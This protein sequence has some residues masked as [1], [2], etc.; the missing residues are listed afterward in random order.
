MNRRSAML[1]LVERVAEALGPDAAGVVFVGG[2]VPA[3]YDL[4]L[5]LRPT[6]DVDLTVDAT[7]PR[8][9]QL[10]ERLRKRGFKECRDPGAPVCRYELGD[11]RLLVDVMPIDPAVLG[12]S[13]RWYVPAV[14]HAEP[15]TLPGGRKVRA[16]SPVYF[17]ATKLEAFRG[18]GGNDYGMSHD[19]ED[20]VSLLAAEPALFD[21]IAAAKDDVTAYLRDELVQL[22]GVADFMDALAWHYPGTAGGE[23]Q[24]RELGE[25][26]TQIPAATPTTEASPA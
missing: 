12:F 22:A 24:A 8:Y 7:R 15:F 1:A 14:E 11:P 23:A 17:L 5:E 21:V 20:V 6:D 3:L 10:V 16:L 2:I 26:L 9:E 25:R 13:N 4:P 18:R 19:L